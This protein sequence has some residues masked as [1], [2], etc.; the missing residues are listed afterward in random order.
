MMNPVRRHSAMPGAG[1]GGGMQASADEIIALC[2]AKLGS[3]KAPK[4]VDFWETLPRSSVG[5]VLK[6]EVRKIF[7]V[8]QGRQI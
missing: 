7:W 3:V 6:R 8:G 2:K 1:A 4:S 5:K